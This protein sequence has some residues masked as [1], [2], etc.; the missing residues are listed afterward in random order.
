MDSIAE[1]QVGSAIPYFLS[2]S[3]I[4]LSALTFGRILASINL[5]HPTQNEIKIF[6]GN[7]CLQSSF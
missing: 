1:R 7:N 5:S 2:I 4:M 6:S 3:V